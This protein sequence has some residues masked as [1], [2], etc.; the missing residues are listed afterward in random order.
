MIAAEAPPAAGVGVWDIPSVAGR[1]RMDIEYAMLELEEGVRRVGRS[2]VAS[3][4]ETGKAGQRCN[5][6]RV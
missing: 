3:Q 1:W 6:R 2:G 4:A 5:S